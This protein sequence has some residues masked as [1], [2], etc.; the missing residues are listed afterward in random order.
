MVRVR[1]TEELAAAAGVSTE[2]VESGDR[3]AEFFADGETDE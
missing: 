1:T 3:A 2:D